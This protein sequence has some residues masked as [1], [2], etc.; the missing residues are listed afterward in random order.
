MQAHGYS[1]HTSQIQHEIQ[2]LYSFYR[3]TGGESHDPKPHATS[4][5][6]NASTWYHQTGWPALVDAVRATI[7]ESYFARAPMDVLFP[8]HGVVWERNHVVAI[9]LSENGLCGTIPEA[10]GHLQFLQ[11]LKLRNNPRLGG[12]L[13]QQLYRMPHLRYCYVDGTKVV[14][15]L[16][17]RDAHA[18]QITQLRSADVTMSFHTGQHP[19]QCTQWIADLPVSSL[20]MIQSALAA[21]HAKPPSPEKSIERTALNATGPERIAAAIKL[22]RIYRA[23]MERTKIRAFLKSIFEK[24]IDPTTGYEYFVDSRTGM[25]TWER[26]KLATTPRKTASSI[27]NNESDQGSSDP[28]DIWQRFDDGY[29]N[30]VRFSLRVD[31]LLPRSVFHSVYSRKG[32]IRLCVVLLE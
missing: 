23:R 16:P 10:I 15:A 27:D 2:A 29:G 22:Q 17:F 3:A 5:R 4:T 19:H 21:R 6:R 11:K 14:N 18:L 20:E 26:P 25:S 9:D 1:K 31:E 12:E 30:T 28:S 32:F 8:L 24:R 7:P 13:P